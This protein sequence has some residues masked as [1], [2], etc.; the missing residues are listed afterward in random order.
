MKPSPKGLAG[1][2]Q[3]GETVNQLL[4][5]LRA[6]GGRHG[7][8]EMAVEGLTRDVADESD[9]KRPNFDGAGGPMGPASSYVE[10]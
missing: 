9:K 2:E 10:S 5:P 8:S 3:G 1:R 7:C 6:G 4:T